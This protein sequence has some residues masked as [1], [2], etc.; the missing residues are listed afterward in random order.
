[1]QPCRLCEIQTAE[2]EGTCVFCRARNRFWHSLDRLPVVA[3]GWALTN[4]RIW[5]GVVEEE[6][7]K[8]EEAREARE[9][10][11]STTAPKSAPA[12]KNANT[13]REGS[14]QEK[15]DK[16]D[17]RWISPRREEPR[18]GEKPSPR[19]VV[20]IEGTEEGRTSSA[21]KPEKEKRDKSKRRSNSRQRRPRSRS[22][23]RHRRR[24]DKTSSPRTGK[25]E[26]KAE[27]EDRGKGKKA[28][29]TVK[30]PTTPSRSP[31][32]ERRTGPPSP[33]ARPQGRQ[34]SGPIRTWQREPQYWGQNKGRGKKERQYYFGR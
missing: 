12:S 25:K 20:D 9:A 28:K 11:E 13:P 1:M 3:R 34:W 10:A 19:G 18:S 26:K 17:K 14:G 31:A 32:R 24:R 7:E 8:L 22:R 5:T 16:P 4:L 30:P 2:V 21:S 23:S 6:C 15:D 29:P 27:S 33:V